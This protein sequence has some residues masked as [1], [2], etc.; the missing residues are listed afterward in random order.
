VVRLTPETD[1]RELIATIP[2]VFARQP[3]M[4]FASGAPVE[5][6]PAAT[7]DDVITLRPTADLTPGEY[8]VFKFVSGQPW[9]IEGYA[10]EVGTT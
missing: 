2:D 5:L 1:H 6:D 8:L 3:Q 9:L 7:A 4:K 10:F